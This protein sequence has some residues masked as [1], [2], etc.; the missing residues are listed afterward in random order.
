MSRATVQ[1]ILEAIPAA[2]QEDA[3]Q[4]RINKGFCQGADLAEGEHAAGDRATHAL[5]RRA[6]GF[7]EENAMP[8]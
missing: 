8:G 7:R 5:R 6:R 1:P 2:R 3:R 4:S